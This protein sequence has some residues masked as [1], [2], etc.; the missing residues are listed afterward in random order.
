MRNRRRALR[1][2]AGG[3]GHPAL[4]LLGLVFA[5]GSRGPRA[6]ALGEEAC[7]HC[8][9]TVVD[10]RFSAEAIT[11]NG[12]TYVFDDVGCLAAWLRETPAGVASAWVWSF[13]PGEGW[14]PAAEVEYVQSD[15]LHTP[16]GSGLAAF[17]PGPGADT[18]Q[19]RL[20]GRRLTWDEV[21]AAP[22]LHTTP[23]WS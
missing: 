14:L 6:I 5:C 11:S 7:S 4:W 18:L 23:P 19:S 2:L 13:V 1:I 3:G 9:M 8:H 21:R 15:S 16:M 22:H 10:P 20:A 17:R 12:K